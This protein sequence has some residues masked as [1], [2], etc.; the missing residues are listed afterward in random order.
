MAPDAGGAYPEQ[1]ILEAIRARGWE[2]KVQGKPGDWMVDISAGVS[3]EDYR[4]VAAPDEDRQLA[5]LRALNAALTWIDREGSR[6]A[7]DREARARLGISGEEFL[8]RWDAGE[9]AE[10]EWDPA[11]PGVRRLATLVPFGR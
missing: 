3:L 11:Q 5:V 10:A 1:A 9:Y 2:M 8:R 7:S 4:A 6:R